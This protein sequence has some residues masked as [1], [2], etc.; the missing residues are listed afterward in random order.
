MSRCRFFENVLA[1]K[2][3]STMSIPR[4]QRNSRLYSSCSHN[5]RS[6]RT[7]YSAI[8][9]I[10]FSKRSG[11]T[12]G[13]PVSAYI[14]S[15]KGDIS[16]RTSSAIPRMA[17]SGWSSEIRDSALIKHNIDDCFVSAPRMAAT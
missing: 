15:N 4:N 13:R 5:C 1:S 17:R 3:G 14:A 9:T 11:G 10:P 6:L 12:E 7:V 8:K 16:P 2:L